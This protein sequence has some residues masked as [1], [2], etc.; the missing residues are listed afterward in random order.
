MMPRA[1]IEGRVTNASKSLIHVEADF[2]T[3]DD[4]LAVRIN[5]VQVRRSGE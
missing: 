2:I 4:K 5:A 1:V 3:P